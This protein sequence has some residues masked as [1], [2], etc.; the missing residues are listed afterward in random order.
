MAYALNELIILKSIITNKMKKQLYEQPLAEI[1]E[2]RLQSHILDGSP[3][4]TNSDNHTEY[5]GGEENGGE[6][7]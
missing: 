6:L 1:F 7:Y 2:V 5:L 3:N 4:G